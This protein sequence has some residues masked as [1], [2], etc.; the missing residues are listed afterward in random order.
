MA[1]ELMVIAAYVIDMLV[2]DPKF[3]MHPVQVIGKMIE[4]VEAL[5]RKLM[6]TSL[7]EKVGGVILTIIVTLSTYFIVKEITIIALWLWKPFG[8]LLII[9]LIST[10]FATNSLAKAAHEVYEALH[11]DNLTEARYKISMIVGRDTSR[12][13]EPEIIR[14]TVE[15]V[16]ENT[17]DGIIS[18]LFYAIIGGAP[19]A[20]T[21]KAINTLDSMVGYKNSK[22]INFGWASARLDD[23]ANWIPARITGVLFVC[24]AFIQGYSGL[25][26]FKTW[27][28]DAH[29]HPSPNGGI[30]EASLAGAL[31]I[32][33]GGVNYYHGME[34]FR[35][36]MGEELRIMEKNDILKTIRLMKGSTILVLIVL[37]LAEMVKNAL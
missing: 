15:T 11:K 17:V 20:M 22:Y 25:N 1:Q 30:P 35:A 18:P 37:I 4:I 28:R 14:A 2:G 9:W 33:L 27:M 23:I 26:A 34:S 36:Y 6:R 8:I 10:T 19:L 21:Y 7:Q 31:G 12:M 32:R 5:L 3:L 16:A 24:I 29:K 13:S